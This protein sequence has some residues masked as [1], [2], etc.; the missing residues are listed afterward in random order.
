MNKCDTPEITQQVRC[1]AEICPQ[2][3]QMHTPR[4]VLPNMLGKWY[5][6]DLNSG[7]QSQHVYHQAL[8]SSVQNPLEYKF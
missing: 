3:S 1:K 2:V 6:Q 7:L 8:L 4:H 5:S